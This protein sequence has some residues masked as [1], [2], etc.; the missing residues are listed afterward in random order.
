[1]ALNFWCP[2]EIAVTRAAL[3][4][5]IVRWYVAFSTLQPG[6]YNCAKIF[7]KS[8]ADRPR[9]RDNPHKPPPLVQAV[10]WQTDIQMD[11]QMDE[12]Y[13][14]HICF[15][16][17]KNPISNYIQQQFIKD[18]IIVQWGRKMVN[19]TSDGLPLQPGENHHPAM[20]H[21]DTVRPKRM[22]LSLLYMCHTSNIYFL[23]SP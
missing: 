1:M 16:V 19:F 15:E 8:K 23:R 14:M 5:H 18:I 2:S 4:A 21:T 7:K 10:E 9:P 22:D 20:F 6:M 12:H 13:Q 3:S 11:R 17:D